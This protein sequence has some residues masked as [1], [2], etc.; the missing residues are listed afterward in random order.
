MAQSHKPIIWGPFAAGGTLAALI[1]PVLIFITGVAVPLG[2][3]PTE[4]VSYD[5]AVVF[6]GTW[7]GKLI[8]FV[9]VVLPA[10]HAAHRTRITLHDFGV[11]ADILVA[12][13]V[14]ILAAVITVAAVM[15]L[16]RI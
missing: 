13:V 8:L 6:A 14:Y 15:A 1:M 4:I 16:L 9:F 5:R 11:R 10:W 2:I 3:L 12:G 7:F